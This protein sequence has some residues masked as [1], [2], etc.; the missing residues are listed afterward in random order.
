VNRI[1][2]IEFVTLDG[3]VEDPD[4]WIFRDGPEAVANDPFR[5]GR[6]LDTG[7]LLLGRATW[8]LFTKIWPARSDEF[9][10]K[11]N[12]M[13]K[14]VASRTLTDVS[15]WNNS[16]VIAGELASE[17]QRLRRDQDVIVTGSVSVAH[18]LMEHDLVGEYRLLVFPAVLGTGRRLFT[19]PAG[20][21]HLRLV[22]TE[23]HGAAAL[24][25]YEKASR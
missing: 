5:L 16:Q 14:W 1:M 11:W 23:Q 17:A 18:T 7:A 9:A 2:V 12:A 24:L 22:S 4:G 25:R 8:E 15:A 21:G 10:A 6:L 20:A 19:S 3:V 13:P